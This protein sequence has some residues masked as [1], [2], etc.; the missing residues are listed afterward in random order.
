MA[1]AL[2]YWLIDI[3]KFQKG[4][5]FF[6]IVGMNPLFIYLFA[7][8]GGADLIKK[9]VLPFSHGLFGWTGELSANIILS[10]IVLYLLWYI[11][12]WLYKK[13][14]FFRI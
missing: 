4:V 6:A 13:K 1:L 7:H 14:I 3:K 8:V 12:Y 9:I 10:M 2:S 11:C 5:W